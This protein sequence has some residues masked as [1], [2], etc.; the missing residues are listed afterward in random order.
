MRLGA[1]KYFDPRFSCSNLEAGSKHV[2]QAI[3]YL[4]TNLDLDRR[5]QKDEEERS[6][7]KVRGK[8]RENSR[9][10]AAKLKPVLKDI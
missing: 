9:Y 6:R 4:D 8:K 10:C 2:K 5:R 1:S 7:R 3:N